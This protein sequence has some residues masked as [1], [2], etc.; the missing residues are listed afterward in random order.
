MIPVFLLL[1]SGLSIEHRVVL[2]TPPTN[3]SIYAVS[4]K[5]LFELLTV[6]VKVTVIVPPI[7][8]V[9]T[10]WDTVPEEG[11]DALLRRIVPFTNDRATS[12]LP[13]DLIVLLYI[14]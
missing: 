14:S 1:I 6:P 11:L 4:P 7:A 5:R 13:L 10:V 3:K 9:V 2:R 12:L 8:D